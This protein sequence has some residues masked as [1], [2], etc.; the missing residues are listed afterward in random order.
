MMEPITRWSNLP[1]SEMRAHDV[2][3]VP[4]GWPLGS[5]QA[6]QCPVCHGQQLLPGN[7]YDD[8]CVGTPTVNCRSC[9]G[10]GVVWGTP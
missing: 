3:I 5:Y 1:D 8:G 10:T 4:P 2:I 7:F 9:N 6:A